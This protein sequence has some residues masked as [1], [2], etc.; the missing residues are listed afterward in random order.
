MDIFSAGT[1]VQLALLFHVLGFLA[2]GELLLRGLLL[3]GTL[4]YILYYFNISQEPLWDAILASSVLAIVNLGMIC[5]L[6][7]E[8]TTFSM[9]HQTADIY[10]FF[11][12]LSPGQ[13]RRVLR[14]AT[15]ETCSQTTRLCTEHAPNARLF[16]VVSGKV[17]LE[18]GGQKIT[19]E[20]RMFIGEVGFLTG[21]N[22]SAT[23]EV[24]AGSV[25]A[26]WSFDDIRVLMDRSRAMR[27]ALIALF[28]DDMAAKIARSAP[29][30]ADK[31]EGDRAP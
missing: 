23:V 13:F 24:A 26:S 28:S 8:R 21:Q 29:L 27:N 14:K 19:R 2:R 25:V 17:T 9:S 31:K 4:F 22:A 1:L 5:W 15:I 11:T 6:V 12:T 20:T 3:T 30:N 18:K 7:I 10:R 16:A